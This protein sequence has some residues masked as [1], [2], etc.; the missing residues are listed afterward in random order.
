[1]LTA[2]QAF[3]SAFAQNSG[4]YREDVINHQASDRRGHTGSL[5]ETL[6]RRDLCVRR[7]ARHAIPWE[8]LVTAG[9]ERRMTLAELNNAGRDGFVA[10]VG[11]IFEHSPWAAERAWDR[12]PF[13]SFDAMHQAMVAEVSAASRDEQL[14]LL[15]AHPDLGSRARMTDA[16][17]REQAGAGLDSLTPDEFVQ[18]QQL[19]TAYRDKFGFPFLFA[20][21][22]ASKHDILAALAARLPASAAEEF[23][24]ALRQ[25]FRIAWFRLEENMQQ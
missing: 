15:R 3:A 4:P 10:A 12:R 18:L 20:V 16:S 22:G 9:S 19:N 1:L 2:S 7:Q 24:E 17:T 5:R 23:P 6:L 8:A 11:W 13:A 25:V 21:K 14:A